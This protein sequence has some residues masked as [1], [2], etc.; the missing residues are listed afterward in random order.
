MNIIVKVSA[1]EK[2]DKNY[3]ALLHQFEVV[4]KGDTQTFIGLVDKIIEIIPKPLAPTVVDPVVV[5]PIGTS[6]IAVDSA[7]KLPI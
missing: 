5:P 4:V 6:V 1:H 3:D 7:P 2:D